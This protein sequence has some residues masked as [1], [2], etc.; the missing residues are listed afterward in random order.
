MNRENELLTLRQRARTLLD[1]SAPRD[2]LAAYY[3]LY[4]DPARTRL[5][6][7][8]T[9]DGFLAVC[10]TG[11]DLFRLL[12]VLRAA[13][14][15]SASK[16]MEQALVAG[17]PYYLLTTPELRAAVEEALT[18]ERLEVNRIYRLDLRRYVPTLNVLVTPAPSASGTPRFVIRAQGQVAAEAGINWQSPHFAEV[19][20]WTAPEV[21]GRGWGKAVVDGCVA[22]IIRS[23]AQPLY[24]VAED[25]EPS[26]RLAESIG[27]VDTGAR[28]LAVEGVRREHA[29]ADS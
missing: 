9:G 23:G 26:I 7:S 18:I 4:H 13:R 14:A 17:R 28:E 6:L 24:I 25:N 15:E 2:G 21:R 5:W 11:R 12:A 10:Q 20:V 29:L 22:W 27:F 1:L 19:Y 16:L 8:Q 3:A